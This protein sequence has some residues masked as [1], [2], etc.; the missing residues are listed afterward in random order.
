MQDLLGDFKILPI[1]TFLRVDVTPY[2]MGVVTQQG[3]YR[4]LTINKHKRLVVD[5]DDPV[6]VKVGRGVLGELL[7]PLVNF[8]V[9]TLGLIDCLRD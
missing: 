2:Q 6:V 8:V 9:E 7:V 3:D 5:R 1:D 4:V